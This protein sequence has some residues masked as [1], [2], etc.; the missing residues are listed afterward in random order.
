[1]DESALELIKE[2]TYAPLERE[3]GISPR[4]II[5]EVQEAMAPCDYV[6]VKSEDRMQEAL[7]IVTDAASKLGQMKVDNYHD[8]VKCIEAEAMTLGG[9]LFYRTSM[10]RKESRGFHLREDYS[11]M[12]DQNWMK[13]IIVKKGSDGEMVFRTEDVPLEQY[14]YKPGKDGK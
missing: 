10:M 1:M 11:E 5:H 13:W 12:D 14:D 4:D 3:N 8:L 7:D 9:E 6:F 2:A